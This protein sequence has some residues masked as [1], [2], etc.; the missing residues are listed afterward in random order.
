MIENIVKN[1]VKNKEVGKLKIILSD[2]LYESINKFEINFSYVSKNI[3]ILDEYDGKE[4]ENDEEKWNSD[5]VFVEKSRLISNF[6][7]ERINHLKKVIIYLYPE[8]NE[9]IDE[10]NNK[11]DDIISKIVITTGIVVLGVGILNL[12]LSATVIGALLVTGGVMY[13]KGKI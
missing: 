5:Y 11:E 3:D 12:K 6:S 2:Y 9:K 10:T 7:I 8:K 4:F 1:Y 13:N